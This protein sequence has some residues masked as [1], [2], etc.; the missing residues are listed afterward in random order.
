MNSWMQDLK[1]KQ[2]YL[3]RFSKNLAMK[4]VKK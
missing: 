4:M 2:E 3:D 1:H